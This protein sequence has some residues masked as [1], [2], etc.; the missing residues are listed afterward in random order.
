MIQEAE[1]YKNLGLTFMKLDE[2]PPKLMAPPFLI[3]VLEGDHTGKMFRYRNIIKKGP[4]LSYEIK[5][6]LNSPTKGY[7]DSKSIE[8]GL[9]E[10][11]GKILIDLLKEKHE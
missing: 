11:S 8:E 2:E 9:T 5:E 3:E 10:L 4:S 7:P 1:G 6:V